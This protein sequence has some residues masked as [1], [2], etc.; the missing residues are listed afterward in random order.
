M[1]SISTRNLP[2]VFLV[3]HDIAIRF[4]RFASMTDAIRSHSIEAIRS[5]NFWYWELLNFA[6]RL[7]L[8]EDDERAC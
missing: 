4:S 1:L 7:P 2:V 6:P 5:D 3:G 8:T